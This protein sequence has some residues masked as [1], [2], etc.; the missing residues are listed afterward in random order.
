MKKM[1]I[2]HRYCRVGGDDDS[3]DSC[4]GSGKWEGMSDGIEMLFRDRICFRRMPMIPT[5]I[6]GQQKNQTMSSLPTRPKLA[7][8]DVAIPKKA[9]RKRKKK[10][11]EQ[12]PFSVSVSDER[13][14]LL[15]LLQE[16]N[17]LLLLQR[18][19]DLASL[20]SLLMALI[21]RAAAAVAILLLAE[22]L[23]VSVLFW[24]FAQFCLLKI[25]TN[26]SILH[27]HLTSPAKHNHYFITVRTDEPNLNLFFATNDRGKERINGT[28]FHKAAQLSSSLPSLVKK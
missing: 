5:P 11:G 14:L 17:L 19:S 4:C 8:Q 20:V 18:Y 13:Q 15:L 10:R 16:K 7:A 12:Q 3:A 6:H 25:R 24:P 26:T 27:C 1:L 2:L 28:E 9:K 22:S 21:L 23:T